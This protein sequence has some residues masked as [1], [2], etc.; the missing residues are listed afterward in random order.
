MR[1][2]RVR[3]AARSVSWCQLADKRTAVGNPPYHFNMSFMTTFTQPL[4]VLDALPTPR[5][6]PRSQL[7]DSRT[8]PRDLDSVYSLTSQQRE[9]YASK[10]FVRCATASARSCM[11]ARPPVYGVPL[12][13]SEPLGVV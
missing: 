11:Q 9:Q 3:K 8:L 12:N 10:G 2:S 13:P 6:V 7:R 5:H 4:R 1:A